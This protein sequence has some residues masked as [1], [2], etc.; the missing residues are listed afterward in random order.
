MNDTYRNYQLRLFVEKQGKER[1]Q[2]KWSTGLPSILLDPSR[3]PY[4]NAYSLLDQHKYK[5][6]PKIQATHWQSKTK[7]F[8]QPFVS[9]I[10]RLRG[11]E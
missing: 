5:Y 11:G 9:S 8:Q 6:L 3:D 2:I 10:E 1:G 4:Q 7:A